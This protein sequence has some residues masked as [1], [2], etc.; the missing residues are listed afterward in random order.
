MTTK[1]T[2]NDEILRTVSF[3][4]ILP[5]FCIAALL[6]LVGFATILFTYGSN[7]GFAGFDIPLLGWMIAIRSE[8]LTN[9]MIVLTNV[10]SPIGA[11]CATIALCLYWIIRKNELWRPLLLAGG[12]TIIGIVTTAMKLGFERSR[13]AIEAMVHPFETTFAFPS[14]HTTAVAGFTL[15]ATYLIVSRSYSKRRLSV[16]LGASAFAILTVSFTRLYLGYHW[17]TDVT[18]ALFLVVIILSLVALT[19]AQFRNYL[20]LKR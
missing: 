17:L 13:P 16:F 9:A 14:G 2:F 19:D 1:P 4:K 10:L 18:A 20:V 6:S 12:M 7:A 11:T 5:F 15:L 3:R 8:P